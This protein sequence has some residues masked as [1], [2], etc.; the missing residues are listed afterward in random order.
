MPV[1][2]FLRLPPCPRKLRV[3]ENSPSLWP[4]MFSVTNTGTKVLPLCTAM[5][6]P[7]MSGMIIDARDQVLITDFLFDSFDFCTF[8]S[9]LWKTYGP[10]L[11]DLAI[12]YHIISNAGLAS[13]PM[14]W[15]QALGEPLLALIIYC[16]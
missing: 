12:V 14:L 8:S 13:W 10:F 6:S 11:I 5:V 7:T 4:T 3:G 2:Y 9:N 16:F 1:H 15:A